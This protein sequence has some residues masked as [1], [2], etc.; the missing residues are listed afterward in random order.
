[1]INKHGYS[2]I[3]IKSALK[4]KNNVRKVSFRYDLLNRHDIK[5]GE[6]DGITRANVSY[7]DFRRIKRSATF[8]LNDYEQNEI[9]FM[10]NSIQPWFVLHMPQGGV[11]EYPLGIFH[12]QSP[13]RDVSKKISTR[14]IGAY[15]KL[16]I[17]ERDKFTS[18]FLVA[19]GETYVGAVT[20]I[21]S[22]SNIVKMNIPDNGVLVTSDREF[23]IGTKKHLACNELLKAINYNTLWV[24]T[25]GFM[26]SEPYL[27]PANRDVAHVYSSVKDS[28]VAPVLRERLDIAERHNIFVRVALNLDDPHELVSV[29]ENSDPF[30]PISTFNTMRSVNYDE[31]QDI[32]SQEALDAFVYRLAVESTTAFTHLNFKTV[33][34]PTHGSGDILLCDFPELWETPLRFTETSWEMP[35]EHDGLMTHDARMVVRI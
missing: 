34:M 20:R 23:P 4:I 11:V 5:I 9:D 3:E 10:S 12:L 26:R 22:T 27:E 2:D 30:S 1:M 25:D 31:V 18:R 17:I 19:K 29:F 32:S 16:I 7:G 35:L 6:L 24:D 13:E 28:I 8:S 21:L 33:L 14:N 15:D